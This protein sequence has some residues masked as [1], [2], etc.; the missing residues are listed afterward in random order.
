MKTVRKHNS[1]NNVKCALPERSMNQP[2]HRNIPEM[3]DVFI[4]IIRSSDLLCGPV[5][6]VPGCNP[7]DPRGSILGAT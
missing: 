4:A 2:I 5:D 7:R 1:A 3:H 6:R